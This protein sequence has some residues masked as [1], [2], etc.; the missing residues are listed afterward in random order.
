VDP[1]ACTDE[2]LM[3]AYV[4]GDP[5]AFR[6]LFERWAPA[7][8][9][10]FRRQGAGE[11]D[12]RDLVQQTFLQVHRARFDYTPGR[13]VRPWILTIG[14]NLR[15][16]LLRRLGRRPASALG[17]LDPPA[18]PGRDE[19]SGKEDVARVRAALA[20]LPDAQR[21]VIELHWLQGLPMAEVAAVVGASVGAVKVRAHRG[22]E[23]LRALLDE[24]TRA[25]GGGG[26]P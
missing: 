21:E 20:R 10:L 14:L 23:R 6:T 9:G 3:A 22:Y 24:S 17:E 25:G 18:P 13:P 2:E 11:D 8:L 12:A 7:L 1:G 19:V 26:A 16:E 4:A 5:A 15:R